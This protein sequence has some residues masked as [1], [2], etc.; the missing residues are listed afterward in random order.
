LEVC[1]LRS[2]HRGGDCQSR[3]IV[4]FVDPIRSSPGLCPEPTR[5]E[6]AR[7]RARSTSHSVARDRGSRKPT[8]TPARTPRTLTGKSRDGSNLRSPTSVRP[9]SRTSPSRSGFTPL[10]WTSLAQPKPT[11]PGVSKRPSAMLAGGIVAFIVIALGAAYFLSVNR[12]ATVVSTAT[13]P[14]EPARLSIVVL[15]MRILG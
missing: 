14:A 13:T 7:L 8:R 6:P 9:N 5:H 2:R 1:Y 3:V 11:K 12:T 15:P 4:N 10:K